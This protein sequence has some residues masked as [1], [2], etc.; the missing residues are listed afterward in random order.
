M[1]ATVA[2]NL[3][4]R[5]SLVWKLCFKKSVFYFETKW[6]PFPVLHFS[7]FHYCLVSNLQIFTDKLASSTQPT[8]TCNQS[9]PKE[10][11]GTVQYPT[12]LLLLSPSK[13]TSSIHLLISC[14]VH[15]FPTLIAH[16]YTPVVAGITNG[17]LAAPGWCFSSNFTTT[18]TNLEQPTGQGIH[19]CGIMNSGSQMDLRLKT[20]EL[21]LQKS[22]HQS[23]TANQLLTLTYSYFEIT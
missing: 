14:R 7:Q 13:Q 16:I 21:G 11:F 1:V 17:S 10:V 22:K 4:E 2:K 5:R 8:A 12:C 3:H 20:H 23:L 19:I 15:T 9:N 18:P 6:C